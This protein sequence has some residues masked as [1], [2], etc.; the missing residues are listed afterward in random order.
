MVMSAEGASRLPAPPA[1]DLSYY[2][3]LDVGF[4]LESR[5]RRRRW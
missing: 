4:V 5:R 3:W 2:G 1:D